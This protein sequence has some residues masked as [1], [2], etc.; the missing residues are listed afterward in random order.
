MIK[1]KIIRSVPVFEMLGGERVRDFVLSRADEKSYL[2]FATGH[3]RDAVLLSLDTGLRVGEL[4]A[5]RWADVHLEPAGAAKFGYLQIR[6][7]KTKNAKRTVP[8]TDRARRMLESK[9][10]TTTRVFPVEATTLDHQHQK[11]RVKLGFPSD[12]V[13]HSCR[14]TM[15][16]RLGESGADAFTIKRIAG[17]SSITI[18][19]RYVHPTPE[20][21]ER[22]FERFQAYGLT[23]DAVS[24]CSLLNPTKAPTVPEIVSEPEVSQIAATGIQ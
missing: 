17:H 4:V 22:V 2:E 23:T 16:T 3:L 8:L 7:G 12:F 18:S 14:H 10:Q 24:D 11:L 9:L 21:V 20:H 13:I 19:E 1:R 15:L 6:K 5:L